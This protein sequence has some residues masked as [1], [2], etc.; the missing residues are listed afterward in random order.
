[1]DIDAVGCTS[2]YDNYETNI[3]I[4]V[5]AEGFLAA[6][7]LIDQVGMQC[8]RSL[9]ASYTGSKKPLCEK[10]SHIAVREVVKPGVDSN[11]KPTYVH[12]AWL[13][14]YHTCPYEWHDYMKYDLQEGYIIKRIK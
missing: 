5:L 8:F 3:D 13:C 14:E 11:G 6:S 7:Q 4:N 2:S 12:H 9:A 1:M 10:K